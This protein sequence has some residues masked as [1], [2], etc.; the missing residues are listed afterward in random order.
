MYGAHVTTLVEPSAF[1]IS[2]PPSILPQ[3]GD[4]HYPCPAFTVYHQQRPRVN[5][6]PRFCMRA[7]ALLYDA[8][9]PSCETSKHRWPLHMWAIYA[10]P[11][12]SACQQTHQQTRDA[13][14]P[15]MLCHCP[16]RALLLPPTICLPHMFLRACTV[17]PA[18]SLLSDR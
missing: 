12:H 18:A 1:P 3:A 5:S 9:A 4:V 15:S 11:S 14:Y 17:K 2:F 10:Q 16:S 8:A 13:C 7:S 6:D